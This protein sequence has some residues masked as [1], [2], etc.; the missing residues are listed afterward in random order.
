MLRHIVMWNFHDHAQ[1][2]HRRAVVAQ[3]Q[4]LLQSCSSGIPGIRVFEVA[5]A[6]AG[7]ECAP[8]LALHTRVD[9]AQVLAQFPQHPHH[10][11]IKPFVNAVVRERRCMDFIVEHPETDHG[12][13]HPAIV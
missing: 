12:T 8:D 9:D 3:A 7:L 1:G 13:H 2:A 5:T 10:V 4:T 6:A 11:V